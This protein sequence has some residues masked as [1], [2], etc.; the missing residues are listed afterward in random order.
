MRKGSRLLQGRMSMPGADRNRKYFA[1]TD[2]ADKVA[3]RFASMRQKSDE[4]R[5]TRPADSRRDGKLVSATLEEP[6][7]RSLQ[8]PPRGTVARRNVPPPPK[9]PPPP[10]RSR[11]RPPPR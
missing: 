6:V 2:R 5:R 3:C 10:P 9:P 11:T 1:L 7:R 8:G 4:Q